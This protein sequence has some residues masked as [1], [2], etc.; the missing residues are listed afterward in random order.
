MGSANNSLFK[1]RVG[2]LVFYEYRGKPCCRTVPDYVKQTA[3]TKKSSSQFRI[4]V[5]A[6]GYLRAQM[7]HFLPDP[8]DKPMLYGFN[9]A[10]LQWIRA[11]QPD[12]NSFLAS[13][14]FV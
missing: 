3:A 5:R 7:K 11:C 13:N 1:G 6:S 4:A 2:N 14:F 12:E 9:N 8:K 10:I